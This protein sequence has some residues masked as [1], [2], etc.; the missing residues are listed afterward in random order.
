MLKRVSQ[1]IG[2]IDTVLAS[3]HPVIYSTIKMTIY[4]LVMRYLVYLLFSFITTK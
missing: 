4:V 1:L 2:S 3:K